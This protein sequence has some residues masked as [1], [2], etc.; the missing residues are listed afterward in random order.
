MNR[1]DD[2]VVSDPQSLKSLRAAELARTLGIGS[3]TERSDDL[4]YAGEDLF[5]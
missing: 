3:C 1:I 5:R 2:S 4:K